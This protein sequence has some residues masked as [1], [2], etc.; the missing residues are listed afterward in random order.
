M[1]WCYLPPCH[2]V[3]MSSP[4]KVSIQLDICMAAGQDTKK[5]GESPCTLPVL[6]C[7]PQGTYSP[8]HVTAVLV[9]GQVYRDFHSLQGTASVP[10]KICRAESRV[11]SILLVGTV[12]SIEIPFT[13]QRCEMGTLLT[14]VCKLV[15][16]AQFSHFFHCV[17]EA[18]C[19]VSFCSS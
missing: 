13:E 16:A 11:K 14:A 10:K 18:Q 4:W 12:L 17:M 7:L 15:H 6:T 1:R 5:A 2:L 3:P 8:P 19:G 9:P